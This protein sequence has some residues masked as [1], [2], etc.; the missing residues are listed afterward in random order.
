MFN[1]AI[2]AMALREVT[3][4]GATFTWTNKQLD[5]V[6]SVLDRVFMSRRHA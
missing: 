1:S 3:R 6:R 2:A 5:P 4:S